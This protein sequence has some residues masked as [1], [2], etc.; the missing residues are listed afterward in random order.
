MRARVGIWARVG[1]RISAH[2]LG[3]DSVEHSDQREGEGPG[4]A[5]S[6]GTRLGMTFEIRELCCGAEK[7]GPDVKLGTLTNLWSFRRTR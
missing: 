6:R 4:R 7:E 2:F 1:F 3:D 5:S